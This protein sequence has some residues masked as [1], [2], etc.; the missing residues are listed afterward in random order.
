MNKAIL[1]GA[2]S[3]EPKYRETD[4]GYHVLHFKVKTVEEY[5]N[6]DGEV[7][8]RDAYHHV[9][10]FG[11]VA[12]LRRGLGLWDRVA[13]EGRIETRK[14]QDNAGD[15]KTVTQIVANSIDILL[16][17]RAAHTRREETAPPPAEQHSNRSLEDVPRTPPPADDAPDWGDDDIPF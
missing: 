1:V 16:V 17:D 2:V 7:Q 12:Q 3:D 10:A 13:L 6:R 14:Y 5:L 11:K 15:T 9:V 8:S 4:K